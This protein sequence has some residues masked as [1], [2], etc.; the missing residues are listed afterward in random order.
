[1]AV[2]RRLPPVGEEIHLPGPSAQPIL[3][4]IG[5]TTTLVGVTTNLFVL[6]LGIVLTLAVLYVWIRDARHE[7]AELPEDHH[8][9]TQ[10]TAA[11]E[12]PHPTDDAT[13]RHG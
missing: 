7:F 5:V 8:L 13:T 3:L 1:M 4:T 11:I 2:E 6:A 9:I 12:Q 10:D